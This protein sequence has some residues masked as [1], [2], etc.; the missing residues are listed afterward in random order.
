MSYEYFRRRYEPV[1][2]KAGVKFHPHIARHTYPTELLK[3][4]VLVYYVSMLLGNEDLSNTQI[5]LHPSQNAAKQEAK[6]GKFLLDQ[7][8]AD[9]YSMLRPGFGPGSS[10]R[11]ADMLDRTTPSERRHVS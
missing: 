5:Y 7:I 4:G 8:P 9:L 2:P 6:K 11:K 3:Q 10:A 1:A